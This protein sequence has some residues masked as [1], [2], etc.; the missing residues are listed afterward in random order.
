MK[1]DIERYAGTGLFLLA[2]GT[3][4]NGYTSVKAGIFDVMQLPLRSSRLV[5]TLLSPGDIQ[6]VLAPLA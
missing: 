6:T 4:R 1:T 5:T 3:I 2:A